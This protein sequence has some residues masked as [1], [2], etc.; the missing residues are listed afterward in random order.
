MASELN[1]PWS[2]TVNE[3][4]GA[5]NFSAALTM[6]LS[7]VGQSPTNVQALTLAQHT[8]H[9]KM[10]DATI[11]YN[12]TNCPPASAPPYVARIQVSGTASVYANGSTAP[13]GQFSP[14][15][16]CIAGGTSDPNVQFSNITFAFQKP[17][18]NHFGPQAIH[19]VVRHASEDGN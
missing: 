18:A 17:A 16:V 12:P 5:A 7:A 15:Q 9:I 14:L 3:E 4:T 11:T 6:K 19:G 10:T 2:L 1:G 13:F 8:H